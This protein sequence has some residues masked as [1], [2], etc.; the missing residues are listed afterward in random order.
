V[1]V[2]ILRENIGIKFLVTCKICLKQFPS[3]KISQMSNLMF[4]RC[5]LMNSLTF[6]SHC[7]VVMESPITS[8]SSSQVISF[9][10]SEN[11]GNSISIK[12]RGGSTSILQLHIFTSTKLKGE[13]V[14]VLLVLKQV[15]KSDQFAC[16]F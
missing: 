13:V 4:C 5:V 14:Q 9:T 8:I 2:T 12:I 7:V 6:G 11:G 10:T 16:G 1:D 15:K 3:M